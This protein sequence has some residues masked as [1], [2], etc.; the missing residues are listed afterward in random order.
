MCTDAALR[1]FNWTLNMPLD[2]S[3]VQMDDKVILDHTQVKEGQVVRKDVRAPVVEFTFD[4]AGDGA[5]E[6][7]VEG[8]ERVLFNKVQLQ[9]FFEEMEKIQLKLDE[10][11]N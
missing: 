8:R 11:T 10:L 5:Q 7:V 3:Q 2:Y 9:Q 4:V 6:G 1:D